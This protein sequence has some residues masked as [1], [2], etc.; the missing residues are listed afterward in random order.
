MKVH[1]FD[2]NGF[3]IGSFEPQLDPL[4]SQKKKKKVYLIP[5]YTTEAAP[6]VVTEDEVARWTGKQWQILPRP[7]QAVPSIP[8]PH[9]EAAVPEQVVAELTPEAA[10]EMQEFEDKRREAL[11]RIKAA[12]AKGLKASDSPKI[13]ED[14]LFILGV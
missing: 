1:A 9:A 5:P 13:L 12:K 14:V 8:D 11:E 6:P 3:H 4:E 7:E 2:A 10:R